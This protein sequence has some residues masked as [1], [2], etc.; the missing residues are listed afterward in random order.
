MPK[1]PA[2]NPTT[3]HLSARERELLNATIAVLDEHGYDRLTI[4]DVAARAHA[5]KAT[6]YRRWPSKPVLIIAAMATRV[7]RPPFAPPPEQT[8]LRDALLHVVRLL[9]AEALDIHTTIAALI[10][11]AIRNPELRETFE[12]HF[13]KPRREIIRDM[14]ESRQADGE[15]R[16]DIDLD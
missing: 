6:I 10:G 3:A 7:D 12:Q 1:A 8:P 2:L 5:S 4:D 13:V 11:E 15:I 16:H 9:T 14:L